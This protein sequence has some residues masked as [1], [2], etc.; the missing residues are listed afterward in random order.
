[1][2]A[3]G[4]RLSVE[5][6]AFAM[7]V[8]GGGEMASGILQ[9]VLGQR[10]KAEMDGRLYAAG[11]SLMA[12]GLLTVD[13]AS[14]SKELDGR[15]SSMVEV[16]L[17][18]DFTLR[19]SRSARGEEQVLNLFFRRGQIVSE[20]VI[21]DVVCEIEPLASADEAA[22]QVR[23]FFGLPAGGRAAGTQGSAGTIAADLLDQ[24]RQTTPGASAEEVAQRLQEAGLA[25][26]PA[27]LV[28]ED[29]LA[30][31]YRG[32]VLRVDNVGGRAVSE[33]GFLILKGQARFWLLAIRPQEPPVLEV[34]AGSGSRYRAAFRGLLNG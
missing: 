1:M 7:G 27:R 22:E 32:A 11:H 10:E 18:S 21:Q 30:P 15:L 19:C 29:L 33:R 4:V 31:D 23:R 14:Q 6:L 34:L 24:I 17:A 3:Q 12:R 5:E 28:A 20:R 16:M 13:V 8:L 2:A 9:A 26:Q 25:A